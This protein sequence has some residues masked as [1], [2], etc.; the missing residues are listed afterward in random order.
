MRV[1]VEVTV[2][3]F[4]G[5]AVGVAE[6]VGVIE[7]VG[8]GANVLVS[9]RLAVWVGVSVAVVV[10]VAVGVTGVDDGDGLGVGSNSARGAGPQWARETQSEQ[11]ATPNTAYITCCRKNGL[12]Q[13]TRILCPHPSGRKSIS[14]GRKRVKPRQFMGPRL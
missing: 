13:N 14:Q 9:V 1:R 4:E 2:G 8:E 7:T 5:V 3:I 12:L 10:A 11:M 6:G